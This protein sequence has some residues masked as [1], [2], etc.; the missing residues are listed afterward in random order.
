[1]EEEKKAKVRIVTLLIILLILINVVLFMYYYRTRIRREIAETKISTSINM[2]DVVE[3]NK[4]SIINEEKLDKFIDNIGSGE[5]SVLYVKY[6]K[7]YY[8]I[9]YFPGNKYKE[10][11]NNNEA[12]KDLNL[13]EEQKT[14]GFIKVTY[15]SEVKYVFDI[16]THAIRRKVENGMVKTYVAD[17][18]DS[19]NNKDLFEY[20]LDSSKYKV[21]SFKIVYERTSEESEDIKS[22]YDYTESEEV[23]YEVN[24]V[25]GEVKIIIDEEEY[26]LEDALEKGLITPKDILIQAE[27]DRKYGVCKSTSYWDDSIE[28]YYDEY[29]ILKM[30][31]I[32]HN[33]NLYIGFPSVLRKLF[34]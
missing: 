6:R 10:V 23:A 19:R 27:L 1:M 12:F 9:E 14:N 3:I 28:Y 13:T 32:L 16:T 7:D 26:S 2:N 34:R 31:D 25:G 22:I 29:T 18:V 33:D 21:S 20:D 4:T 5:S 24:K 17:F 15:N 11:D 30:N 8:V